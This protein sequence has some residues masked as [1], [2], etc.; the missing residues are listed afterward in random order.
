METLTIT[1]RLEWPN[2]NT[3]KKSSE[4]SG[5]ERFNLWAAHLILGSVI[6]GGASPLL[7]ADRSA[8]PGAAVQPQSEQVQTSPV[9]PSDKPKVFGVK[10][11]Q[12]DIHWTAYYVA[13][14]QK[15]TP[16][17]G[18]LIIVV[19][20]QGNK[21]RVHLTRSSYDQADMEAV[22]VGID[23]KGRK[24]YAYRVEC[25]LWH[26]LPAGAAGMGNELNALVPLTDVA[27]D[28]KRYP[29]GSMIYL[30]DA[31]GKKFADGESFDGYFW[32]ADAGGAIV[33]NH[34]DVFV[35][36]ETLYKDFTSRKLKDR[37]KTTIY[38]LPNLPEAKNPRNDAGLA[39]ILRDI[40]LI[41]DPAEPPTKEALDAALLSFQ[42][43]NSRIPPGEYGNPVGATTLWFLTQAELKFQAERSKTKTTDAI[44]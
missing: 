34:F 28:Q 38:K 15:T 19:D 9:Q 31:V 8:I 26:E 36:D 33:G 23:K 3:M 41:T 25:D 27:A 32:V 40:G 44:K 14:V 21:V 4:K 43:A 30:P 2:L 29:Y 39:A 22:A 20:R 11:V 13:P 42:H 37:Y 10:P 18:H 35:G 1:C 6:L 24:R 17:K 5:S 12:V 16:D 7:G